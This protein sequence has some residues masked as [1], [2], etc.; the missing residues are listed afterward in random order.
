MHQIKS[1]DELPTA[2]RLSLRKKVDPIDVDKY[3][4][5]LETNTFDF[6][7]IEYDLDYHNYFYHSGYLIDTDIPEEK[8]RQFIKKHESTFDTLSDEFIKK[9]NYFKKIS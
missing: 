9:I 3:F 4:N 8:A 2:I 7:M 6:D 1:I 5:L